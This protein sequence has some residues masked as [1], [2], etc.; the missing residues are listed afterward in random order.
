M[1]S[2]FILGFLLAAMP[3]ANAWAAES[4]APRPIPLNRPTMKQYLEEMKERKPRIPLPELI[5]EEKSSTE[6]RSRSYESRL[7]SIY[8]PGMGDGRGGPRTGSVE[9]RREPTGSAQ[10]PNDPSRGNEPGMTLDYRLKT[11]LFWIVSRTNNCQYCLGHQ[12][13]KLLRAG[14]VEDE[15][16]A[17]D[18]DWPL[19]PA[20]EQEAFRFTRRLTLEPHLLSDRD[21][22]AMRK[23]FTDLQILEIVLSVSGN[24]SINRW[25]EGVGVPQSTSGGGFG[26]PAEGVASEPQAPHSYLTPTSEKFSDRLTTVAPTAAQ[27]ADNPKLSPTVFKRADLES[28]AE[29]EAALKRAAER[30]PRLPLL[31]ED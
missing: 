9:R 25:K 21:I 29:V 20:A 18:C 6:D 17:L 31:A 12:E 16:A 30:T 4:S 27:P 28:R 26:R 11:S 15:I 13:S 14:M 3:L 2:T 24:N 22:E 10:R 1:R 5:E 7:R 23:H 19:F 8:M